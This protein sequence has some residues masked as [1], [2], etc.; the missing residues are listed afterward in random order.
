MTTFKWLYVQSASY[1]T[2]TALIK[3]SLLLQ[4][5][6]LFRNGILRKICLILLILVSLWGSAFIF[7]AWFPCFPVSGFWNRSQGNVKCY[8]FGFGSVNGAYITFVSFAA[9][10]MFF[11]TIIFLIPMAEYLKPSLHRKQILAL[12]GLFTLGSV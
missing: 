2:T 11:D 6:R 8:G 7:M 10:N 9:T 1:Y 4:Y 5:L 12:T 3:V